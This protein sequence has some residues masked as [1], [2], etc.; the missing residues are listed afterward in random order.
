[1]LRDHYPRE[2]RG[3]DLERAQRVPRDH[4][5]AAWTHLPNDALELRDGTR[6]PPV[7]FL[8]PIDAAR[9]PASAAAA[10]SAGMHALAVC[11]CQ[12]RG[13]PAAPSGA[14][15]RRH[16]ALPR[17][18]PWGPAH[19]AALNSG[20]RGCFGRLVYEHETGALLT[21]MAVSGKAPALH[22]RE[23][24][25]LSVREAARLQGLPDGFRLGVSEALEARAAAD[26][27][28]GEAVE[29]GAAQGGAAVEAAAVA[30]TVVAYHAIGNAVPPRLGAAVARAARAAGIEERAMR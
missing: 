7:Y 12:L 23:D 19:S 14:E 5:N 22:P 25:I 16:F 30:A 15:C 26:E 17:L 4:P 1:M 24:R 27:L 28:A 18:L 6:V 20:S 29:A 8:G 13:G 2:L 11:S 10:R 9:E 21:T 3:L